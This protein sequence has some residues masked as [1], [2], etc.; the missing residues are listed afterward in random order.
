MTEKSQRA[1]IAL[2]EN[3]LCASRTSILGSLRASHAFVQVLY[4][5]ASRALVQGSIRASRA[6]VQGSLRASRASILSYLRALRALIQE[7]KGL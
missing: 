6:L 1:S 3:S 5:R 2:V 7:L 4:L